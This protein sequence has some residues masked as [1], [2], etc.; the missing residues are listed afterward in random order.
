[1][2]VFGFLLLVLLFFWSALLTWQSCEKKRVLL[3][4]AIHDAL[5]FY[6]LLKF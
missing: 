5:L 6:M 4:K 1:L 2:Q 3:S